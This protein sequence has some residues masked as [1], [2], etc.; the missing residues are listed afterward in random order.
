MFS[1]SAKCDE[2]E[3]E[4]LLSALAYDNGRSGIAEYTRQLVKALSQH[5]KLAVAVLAKDMDDFSVFNPNVRLIRVSNA[6]VSAPMNILWHIILLPL[7]LMSTKFKCLILPAINRRMGIWYPKPVIGIAHDLSQYAVGQKYDAVRML[8]VRHVL[9]RMIN[10]LDHIVAIS[11][12]TKNDLKRFWNVREEKISVHYNGYDNQ[13]FS[14][15]LPANIHKVKRNY[16]LNKPY[17]LFVSRIE[18]PGKNHVRL[19]EA[20]DMMDPSLSEQFELIFAG[21]DWN[22]ASHVKS[23]ASKAKK[24]SQIRFL[25]YVPAEDLAGLYHWAR[26]MV[27]PSLYEGFGIPLVE[28]MA[29]GTAAVCSNNSSLGEIAGSAALTFN[30][31]SSTEIAEALSNALKNEGETAERVKRGL[32]QCKQFCWSKLANYLSEKIE[33]LPTNRRVSLKTPNLFQK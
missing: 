16:A 6:F 24:S 21:S 13:Q 10:S 23:F 26:V 11:H 28:A 14:E 9:P 31:E 19:I 29:C 5:Q 20:F 7:I 25:G 33:E 2:H 17:L 8:Y 1:S 4:I 22:G 27:L 12:N 32:E 15:N 3:N 30:P 18:H